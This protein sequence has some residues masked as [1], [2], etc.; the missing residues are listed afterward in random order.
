MNEIHAVGTG[1]KAVEDSLVR[2][3]EPTEE[4]DERKADCA[5][6]QYEGE[7]NKKAQGERQGP[8]SGGYRQDERYD[9]G[10]P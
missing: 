3:G 6:T 2:D 9:D 10:E 1:A 8:M 7:V 5:A 4:C